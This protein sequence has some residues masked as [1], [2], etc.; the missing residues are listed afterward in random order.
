MSVDVTGGSAPSAE[1][2]KHD[3]VVDDGGAWNGRLHRR[4]EDCDGTQPLQHSEHDSGLVAPRAELHSLH[5]TYESLSITNLTILHGS[6][7]F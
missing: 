6:L 3:T 5:M 2:Y 7:L 4:L 1:K